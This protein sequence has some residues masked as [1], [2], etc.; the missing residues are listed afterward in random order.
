MKRRDFLRRMLLPHPAVI[1]LLGLLSAAVLAASFIYLDSAHPI[2]I[3]SYALSFYALSVFCLRIPNLLRWVERFRRE[4]CWY[5]RYRSDVRLRMNLS[6]ALGFAFNAAYACFQLCLGLWHASVWFY[7]MAVYYLLLAAMRLLLLRHTRSH[8]P[9]RFRRT[10]WRKYRL[11]GACLLVMNL[12]LGVIIAY[13][14]LR[15]REFRHH[16]IT[17]LAMATYTFAAMILAI[18]GAVRYK[19]FGSPVYSAAKAISLVSATV[20]MLTLE[21]AMLTAFG[22]DG[23]E[24]FHQFMLGG[25]GIAVMLIVQGIALHMILN[26]RRNLK[27]NRQTGAKHHERYAK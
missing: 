13:F 16:E 3:A 23:G 27:P 21:N 18:I 7:A 4:N 24:Q 10:E 12:A 20:S 1:A 17:T 2:S 22:V 19:R 14:V 8:A 25:S 26:A 5:M 6:L 9:G 15:I 11:C